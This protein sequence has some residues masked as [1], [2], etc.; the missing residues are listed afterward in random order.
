MH[1]SSKRASGFTLVEMLITLAILGLLAG[2]AVPTLE[3]TVKRQKEQELRIAL[4][5]IRQAIDAYKKAA[6]EGKVARKADESGY[7]P[8]LEALFQGVQDITVPQKK[9]MFFL[10]RLP[11]DPFYPDASASAAETWGKRSYESDWDKPREG[12]DVYDVYSYSPD[13][14]LDGTRYRNW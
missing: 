11:R 8:K 5:D 13:T 9:M 1:E 7:P 3:L 14:A 10:R 4:R 12:K 6:D 2:L